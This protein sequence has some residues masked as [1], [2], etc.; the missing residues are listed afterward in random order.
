MITIALTLVEKT[1]T[2]WTWLNMLPILTNVTRNPMEGIQQQVQNQKLVNKFC[3]LLQRTNQTGNAKG[4]SKTHEGKSLI[5]T[6]AWSSK[7][8]R[9][10]TM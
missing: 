4:V 1:M 7:S 2:T 9:C 10:H 5:V 8:E 6:T 3:N